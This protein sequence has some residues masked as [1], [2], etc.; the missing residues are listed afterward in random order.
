VKNNFITNNTAYSQGGGVWIVNYSDALLVQ[1]VIA[2]NHAGTGGGVYW[3]VPSGNRGPFLINNTIVDNDSAQ[4]SAIFA[5]GFD[6]QAQVIN[7][8][9]VSVNNQNTVVCGTYD[10]NAPIFRYND[11]V[12]TGGLAY[13]GACANQTGM[14]GNISADPLFRDRATGDYHLQ[15][16]SFAIDMGTSDGAPTLDVDGNPRPVDG[17]GDGLA[18]FDMGA[19]EAPAIDVTPPITSATVSPNPNSAGWNKTNT[20]VTLSATDNS[21]GVKSIRYWLSGAQTAPNV[22]GGNP[23]LVTITAEGT[24]TVGFSAI[25]NAGNAETSKSFVVNI[26]KTAP[27]TTA[28]ASASPNSA[29]W[30][31]TDTTVTL[32]AT[33]NGSGVHFIRYWLNG[34]QNAAVY[35]GNPSFV[36]ITAEGTTTLGYTAID[37]ADNAEISKSFVVNIDKTGPVVSG[38]PGNGCT[39]APPKHQLVQ[40]ATITASDARSGVATLTVTASSNEPDSGLGGGDVPGDIVINGG[41]VQLRAERSPSGKGR[42]YTI[43]AT[44]TDVAGNVTTSTATCQVP[45]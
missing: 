20:T 16:N 9:L 31:K 38:M 11:V 5:D 29:G 21:S 39:L 13:A 22:D 42:T 14:N 24:T 27:I 10:A 23:A 36:T 7:N 3:L 17:N 2:G 15:G 33:D 25:D 43:V 8:V 1:N 34:D 4:G 18:A 26:D 41:N 32:S 12:S 45:K 35:G 40:V 19:Y 44:A 37:N 6:A 28:T 30:I